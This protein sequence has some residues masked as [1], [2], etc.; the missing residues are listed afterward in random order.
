MYISVSGDGSTVWAGLSSLSLKV[1]TETNVE[2]KMLMKNA[3][4][5][6]KTAEL[7]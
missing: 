5:S 2:D 6:F 3:H 1:R 7:S 4:E